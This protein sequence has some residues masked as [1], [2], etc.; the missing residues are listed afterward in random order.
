MNSNGRRH[1][2]SDVTLFLMRFQDQNLKKNGLNDGQSISKTE[3]NTVDAFSKHKFT[4]NQLGFSFIL[5]DKSKVDQP[6]I[7]TQNNNKLQVKVIFVH[8]VLRASRR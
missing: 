2:L 7:D 3:I 5:Y 4:E 1:T 8:D 6:L